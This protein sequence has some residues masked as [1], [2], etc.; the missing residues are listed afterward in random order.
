MPPGQLGDHVQADAAVR[1][2]AGDVD[3]VGVGQQ[4]VHPELFADRHA[5]AAVLD[6]HGEPGGDQ[7]RAQ[8]DLGVRR[9]E[10]RGVLDEFGQQVDDVGDGVAAQPAVDR[11]HQLDPGVLLDLGDGRAQHLGH[12]DRVAPLAAGDGAAEDGEVLGVAADPGGEVVDVEEALEQVGVLD[13]VLQ[14]VEEGDL[15]VHQG[16]QAP[17]EVDEGLELL[18]AAG[19]AGEPAGLDHGADGPVVGAGEV[20][21]EQFE[22]V[23]VGGRSAALRAPGRFVAVAQRLDEGLQFGLAARGAGAQG[24]DPVVHGAGRAARGDDGRHQG[25]EGHRGRP[26]EHRPQHEAGARPGGAHGEQ[27]GGDRAEGHRG[28]RQHGQ[29]QQVGPYVGLGQRGG[30]AGDRPAVPPAFTA[31]RTGGRCAEV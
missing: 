16:L 19:L 1:E 25:R 22:L 23:G 13:L 6:L 11:R 4:G 29:A 9:G 30:G 20:G 2:Q 14:L 8:Q 3:L 7:A 15:A 26:G 21:G 24:A 10:H 5:Q 12:G 28:R 27:H 17:G 31:V 18:F